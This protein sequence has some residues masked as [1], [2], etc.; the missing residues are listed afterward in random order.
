MSNKYAEFAKY[1]KDGAT[2][3]WDKY[4]ADRQKLLDEIEKEVDVMTFKL[5]RSK[6]SNDEIKR[7]ITQIRK[8]QKQ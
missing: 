4:R 3:R 7:F 8:W 6:L 1:G 2:K 5:I